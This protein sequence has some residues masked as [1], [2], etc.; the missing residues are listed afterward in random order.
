[1]FNKIRHLNVVLKPMLYMFMLHLFLHIS[2]DERMITHNIVDFLRPKLR[3]ILL[4]D[5]LSLPRYE[6]NEFYCCHNNII[7]NFLSVVRQ[8]KDPYKIT[9]EPKEA[10]MVNFL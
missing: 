1:M 2:S 10:I 5:T 8:P 7:L 9:K 6:L 4:N 3:S